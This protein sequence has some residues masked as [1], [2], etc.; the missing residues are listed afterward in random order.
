MRGAERERT[1]RVRDD[2][3]ETT[4]CQTTTRGTGGVDAPNRRWSISDPG[5]AIAATA[6]TAAARA[7]PRREDARAGA[8]AGQ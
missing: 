8:R 4:R 1:E 5:T 6:R 7:V 2:I 3:D